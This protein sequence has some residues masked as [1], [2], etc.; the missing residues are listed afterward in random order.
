MSRIFIKGFVGVSNQIMLVLFVMCLSIPSICVAS[1]GV[2]VIPYL[3]RCLVKRLYVP[4]YTS[5]HS[6]MFSSFFTKD[7]TAEIAAIP[8][9]NA[10][11]C[12]ACSSIAILCSSRSLV[13]F[14]LRE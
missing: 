9:E 2:I 1:T 5:L 4:P 14:A 6:I 3:G 10:R 13:G 12:F 7:E 8:D 11:P